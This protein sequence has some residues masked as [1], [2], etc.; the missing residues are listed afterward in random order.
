MWKIKG[1][2]FHACSLLNSYGE[3]SLFLCRKQDF[4]TEVYMG[5]G[6]TWS[7]LAAIR[8]VM[9]VS[10]ISPAPCFG[11]RKVSSP[12]NEIILSFPFPWRLAESKG[13]SHVHGLG[14]KS[15]VEKNLSGASHV[16]QVPSTIQFAHPIP[17][18]FVLLAVGIILEWSVWWQ[19]FGYF[20]EYLT[21]S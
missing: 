4:V 16:P 21:F 5:L 13:E 19:L 1:T 18:G 8:Q 17:G 20:S 10:E 2:A 3:G 14:V 12:G 15:N 6:T 11:S 7:A 9:E